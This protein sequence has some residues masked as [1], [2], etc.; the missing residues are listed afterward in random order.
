MRYVPTSVEG[1]LIVSLELRADERGF[2]ARMLDTDEFS[3][4]GMESAFPQINTSMSQVAG[5]LR[6]L[7]YQIAPHGEAKLVRC[8]RGAIYDVVVDMRAS[9][10]TFLRWHGVELS[11]ENRTMLY[12]PKG[13][14]HGFM[15]LV[16][17]SEVL[18]PASAF[19]S[20]PHER[21]L[22]WNDPAICIHWPREPSV[23][24]EKDRNARDF[25]PNFHLSGY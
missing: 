23:I 15:T 25:D 18:Y 17:E 16:D 13:C 3:A 10:P 8:I 2:F 11:A 1:S 5:T 12:V 4:N 6:G 7:H 14:A 22:R 24:S 19:Y 21:A 9:S 20:G